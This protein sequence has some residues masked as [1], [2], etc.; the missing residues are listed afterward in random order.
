MHCLKS[1]DHWLLQDRIEKNLKEITNMVDG[2]DTPISYD[3]W[4]IGEFETW[5][6]IF[7]T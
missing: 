1:I 3:V 5:K 4:Y 7:L 6:D 2:L